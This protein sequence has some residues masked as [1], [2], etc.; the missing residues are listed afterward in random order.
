MENLEEIWKDIPG[1]EGH[2]QCSS[3]GEI[4]SLKRLANAK[5]SLITVKERILKSH[6]REG[7]KIVGL[8]KNN[9]QKSFAIHQLVAITFLNHIPCGY[10]IVVDHI[11]NNKLNNHL[12]NL[13][14]ISQRE[15]A[16]KDRKN[17][18][19]FTGVSEHHGKWRC[20]IAI[21]KE[22]RYIGSFETKEKAYEIYNL[23]LQN[24]HKFNGNIT[25]FRK[26]LKVYNNTT[27]KQKGVFYNKN[28]KRW[29]AFHFVNKKR[30]HLGSF[31]TESDA[32][33]ARLKATEPKNY[34]ETN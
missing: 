12:T 24:L 7:Y 20:S 27:S 33:F 26:L 6:L 15:N 5:F 4:K 22:T 32:I 18:S 16:T 31:R 8:C 29:V 1:Y 30:I 9:K 3:Y 17:K 11:D 2:Y 19:G 13:Q 23:A 21:N 28:D 14:V 25:K 34:N 10:K